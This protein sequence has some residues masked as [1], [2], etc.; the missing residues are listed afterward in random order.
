MLNIREPLERFSLLYGLWISALAI[1]DFFYRSDQARVL[2]MVFFNKFEQFHSISLDW[3]G[4]LVI[5]S[6]PPG[7]ASP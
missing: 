5:V 3:F 6:L 2:D 7:F 4:C 1:Q